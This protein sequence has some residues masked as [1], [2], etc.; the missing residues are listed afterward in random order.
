M[1]NKEFLTEKIP[2]YIALLLFA[3]IL[4]GTLMFYSQSNLAGEVSDTTG[5]VFSLLSHSAGN[6]G[7]LISVCLL[8]LI[9][10]ALKLPKQQILK[11]L[12]Q[13]GILLALSF[14][15]KTAMKHLTEVPRPYTYQLQALEI[16]E[17]P[18]NFYQLS[19]K[20]KDEAVRQAEGTVSHWRLSHWLG[21]TNYSLPSGHTIF[22]AVCV[23]F[24]GGFFLRRKKLIPTAIIILWATS[25]GISRIWLGMHW[26]TDLIASLC[27]AAF[28]YLFVPEW[29]HKSMTSTQ[30]T[31]SH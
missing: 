4:S 2:G 20:Q 28:L 1:F 23:T 12:I 19:A 31:T 15:A 17:S 27:G 24:W 21:E 11:L 9:P 22:V 29:G 7:F 14:V 6:P 18:D 10:I 8:C 3:T 30:P 13:F 5:F 26:P 25:V 16:V